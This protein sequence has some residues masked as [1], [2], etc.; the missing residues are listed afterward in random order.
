MERLSFL[1][2]SI[3]IFVNNETISNDTNRIELFVILQNLHIQRNCLHICRLYIYGPIKIT[4]CLYGIHSLTA[5]NV[6]HD[7]QNKNI[8]YEIHDLENSL[9]SFYSFVVCL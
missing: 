9:S 1:F 8:L 7:W 2:E 3:G 5:E 4:V 6:Y